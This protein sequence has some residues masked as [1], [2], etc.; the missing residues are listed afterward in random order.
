M[1]VSGSFTM[2]LIVDLRTFETVDLDDPFTIVNVFF[3]AE[4][5]EMN[6]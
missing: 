1:V 6:M 4:I 3:D 2:C 5:P